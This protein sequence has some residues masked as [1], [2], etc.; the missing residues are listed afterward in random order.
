MTDNKK[1]KNK[2]SNN[3]KVNP[4]QRIEQL[5]KMKTN[6]WIY[7]IVISLIIFGDIFILYCEYN[8]SFNNSIE[9]GTIV[10]TIAISV[11]LI[12][13]F[14]AYWNFYIE[15]LKTRYKRLLVDEEINTIPEELELDID[16][17]L[18][19]LSYKYLDQYYLQTREHAQKGFI[20]TISVSIVGAIIIAGGIIALFFGQTNPAY[21]TTACGVITEFISAIYFYLYNKTIQGMSSYH[22]K[23]VL[24]Q[25]IALALKLSN[26][27]S[28]KSDEAK[29]CIIY[30]L[31][32]DINIHM[33]K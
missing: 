7:I 10:F 31:V 27:I 17:N 12:A 28:D 29:L 26:S 18:I 19:K 2:K 13:F 25:N 4:K 5:N 32:K 1:N 3:I 8:L 11:L 33:E 24:S 15:I 30:E 6:P 20:V 16:K 22:N 14:I 21:I 23:L 9:T